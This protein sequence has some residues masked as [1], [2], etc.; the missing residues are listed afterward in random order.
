MDGLGDDEY[1]E[2]KDDAGQ[3]VVSGAVVSGKDDGSFTKVSASTDVTNLCVTQRVRGDLACVRGDTRDTRDLCGMVSE[4][5][6]SVGLRDEGDGQDQGGGD[7]DEQLYSLYSTV[8]KKDD[9]KGV[10]LRRWSMKS[11]T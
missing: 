5:E 11:S 1:G 2:V 3:G 10:L 6:L 9:E 8:Q 4:S 7:D